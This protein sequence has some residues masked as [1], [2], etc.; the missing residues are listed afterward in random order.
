MIGGGNAMAQPKEPRCFLVV[1]TGKVIKIPQDSD[2][3]WLTLFYSLP[4][5]L[6]SKWKPSFDLPLRPYEFC[7]L[8]DQKEGQIYDGPGC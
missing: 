8:T 3:S 5:E 4:K 2:K 7:G 6:V 1:L